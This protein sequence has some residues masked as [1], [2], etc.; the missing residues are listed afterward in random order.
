MGCDSTCCKGV[1]L[2]LSRDVPRRVIVR[3]VITSG[4]RSTPK[5]GASTVPVPY[6]TR[7]DLKTILY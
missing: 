2:P 7:F 1:L 4:C 5:S 6:F 3:G